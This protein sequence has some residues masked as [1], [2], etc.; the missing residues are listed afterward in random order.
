MNESEDPFIRSAVIFSL[1]D[2]VLRLELIPEENADGENQREDVTFDALL[3][4]LDE[5]DALAVLLGFC[6]ARL[7]AGE[8]FDRFEFLAFLRFFSNL[9][10]FVC[11]PRGMSNFRQAN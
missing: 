6:E 2:I 10:E 1:S 7:L 11:H 4:Y 8:P 3:S 5:F 9:I